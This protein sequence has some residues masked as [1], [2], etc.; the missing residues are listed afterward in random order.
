MLQPTDH[1][2]LLSDDPTL[3][4]LE[5]ERAAQAEDEALALVYLDALL[6]RGDA[7]APVVDLELRGAHRGDRE[8]K[9]ALDAHLADHEA[10]VLG[11][12]GGFPF[13]MSWT[14]PKKLRA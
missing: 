11:R 6:E 1:S 8:A 7:R 3:R 13:R 14:V 4:A 5:L 2:D 12:P 9:K 10:E